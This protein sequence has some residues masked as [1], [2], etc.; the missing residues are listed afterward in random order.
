MPHQFDLSKNNYKIIEN[1]LP[2]LK[3]SIYPSK[4]FTWLENFEEYEIKDFINLLSLFEFIPFNEFMFRID[5]LFSKISKEVNVKDKILIYP[6]GKV[7]KSGTLV[8]YP[9]RNTNSFKNRGGDEFNIITH[10]YNKFKRIDRIRNVIFLDDFIGSGDTFIKAYNDIEFQK[11]IKSVDKPKIFLL[12]TVIMENAFVKIKKQCPEVKIISEV[13]KD[14]NLISNKSN[15]LF[16]DNKKLNSLINYYGSKIN[17]N[18]PMGYGNTGA[19]IS[20]FH[21]TPNNTLPIFWQTNKGWKPLFP[22]FASVRMEEA[23]LLK[24]NILY[25]LSLFD[26]IKFDLLRH[27]YIS[28]EE[29]H[30]ENFSL[31]KFNQKYYEEIALI[32]LAYRNLDIYMICQILG[33]TRDELNII[34][35]RAKNLGLFNYR[36]QLT[37]KAINIIKLIENRKK[38][39]SIRKI[40]DDTLK[41]KKNLYLPKS[42]GGMSNY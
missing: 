8:T 6:Y 12:T 36:F 28:K 32:Y 15:F 7:G 2:K 3:F 27:K 39:D 42:F 20:F 35:I 9:F 34:Y 31:A 37:S 16:H 21:G 26:K 41:I 10:D 33:L 22:R 4:I 1:L 30:E 40:N 14:I 23:R 17:K 19:L 5:L 13:R 25:Y 29:F 11:W 24:K 18:E 38:K